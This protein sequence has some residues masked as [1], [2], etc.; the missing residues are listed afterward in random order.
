MELFAPDIDSNPVNAP[1][2]P[3]AAEM[4]VASGPPQRDGTSPQFRIPIRLS[5][6][7]DFDTF[8]CFRSRSEAIPTGRDVADMRAFAALVGRFIQEGFERTC[9]RSALRAKLREVID[10]E[11]IAMLFQPAVRIDRPGIAFVEALA[12]FPG[13]EPALPSP[14][15]EAAHRVDL[16]AELEL[17]AFDKALAS[18]PELAEGAVL[19]VN[20]SPATLLKP[21]MRDRLAG[22]PAER[23]I[24]EITEHRPVEDYAALADVLRPAR[25]RGLKVAVDDAG[26]GFASL[27]HILV[28][29]PDLIK[30]D[31]SL[32]TGIE[33]DPA[34]RALAAAMM[35]FAGSIG[36]ELVAEGVERAAELSALRALGIPIVQGHLCGYPG[37]VGAATEAAVA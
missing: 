17:L 1:A 6:G 7:T 19:S 22:A 28:L 36:A 15:F 4:I 2:G 13:L 20:M 14:W 12:R 11:R 30:L 23:L 29:R 3:I 25:E 8:C 32:S 21:A 9:E 24:I 27:R 16:G 26:A 18:L 37:P 34:R 35:S 31:M 5:N 33:R 10:G